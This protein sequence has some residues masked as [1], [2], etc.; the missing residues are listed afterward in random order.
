MTRRPPAS[1]DSTTSATSVPMYSWA[2]RPNRSGS[3]LAFS[4][5]NAPWRPCGLPTRPTLMRSGNALEVV[6]RLAPRRRGAQVLR[7]EC[8]C[9]RPAGRTDLGRRALDVELATPELDVVAHD[10]PER[11]DVVFVRHADRSRVDEPPPLELHVRM[12]R[13]DEPVVDAGERF[14]EP[15]VRRRIRKDRPQVVTGRCMAVEDA[16]NLD[17]RRPPSSPRDRVVAETG[18]N[19]VVRLAIAV[20]AHEPCVDAVDELERPLRKWA[21]EDVAA[22]HDRVEAF[23]LDVGEHRVERVRHPV[24]VVERC[25]A[26]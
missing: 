24:D 7:D 25:D 8:D 18:A 10:R 6:C 12:A 3:S 17:R 9:I 15:L 13:D 1:F 23:P 22:E 16:V 19:P 4:T 2:P 14:V 5:T 21:P 20:A 11:R 26:H